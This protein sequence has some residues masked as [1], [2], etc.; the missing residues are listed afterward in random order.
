[1]AGKSAKLGLLGSSDVDS[2]EIDHVEDDH[3]HLKP[4]TDH[5]TNEAH[6]FSMADERYVAK[7]K[8]K[9]HDRHQ[10]NVKQNIAR[11][12]E[13]GRRTA[14]ELDDHMH[15]FQLLRV[16]GCRDWANFGKHLKKF[17]G[18]FLGLPLLCFCVLLL[19][20]M[21]QGT[22]VL[23]N[24]YFGGEH[25]RVALYEGNPFAFGVG[26]A[27]DAAY[28]KYP[29]NET[30]FHGALP[31]PLQ[32]LSK[33]FYYVRGNLTAGFT[34]VGRCPE[35]CFYS[36]AVNGAID[37]TYNDDSP[38]GQMFKQFYDMPQSPLPMLRPDI[39][40]NCGYC[41]VVQRANMF[42]LVLLPCCVMYQWRMWRIFMV[43]FSNLISPQRMML[44]IAGNTL[45]VVIF[46]VVSLATDTD[47]HITNQYTSPFRAMFFWNICFCFALCG[48][49]FAVW[50]FIMASKKEERLKVRYTTHCTYTTHSLHTD[51]SLYT[52]ST[53]FPQAASPQATEE[54]ARALK[55][56]E[57][58]LAA[59]AMFVGSSSHTSTWGG[60]KDFSPSPN[61][62]VQI[63]H[64][65]DGAEAK[66]E[67]GQEEEEIQLNK[68]TSA[69]HPKLNR[70]ESMNRSIK[71][72]KLKFEGSLEQRL[73]KIRRREGSKLHTW[74]WISA[75][76]ALDAFAFLAA[77]IFIF[78][79][80]CKMRDNSDEANMEMLLFLY[81]FCPGVQFLAY[82]CCGKADAKLFIL[83]TVLI[84]Y[85]L[86]SYT[87][88]C[89]RTLCR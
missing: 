35:A 36:K 10:Q 14:D 33:W 5:D 60:A 56:K 42:W 30:Q 87:M 40:L 27:V 89:T 48:T 24:D 79:A 81:C 18:R 4:A 37:D 78:S 57:E 59:A 44:A 68:P 28:E 20:P 66:E 69:S 74:A 88:H 45:I 61:S 64:G 38:Q 76:F 63:P 86:H 2:S 8:A 11:L 3:L 73:F 65:A 43:P 67:E 47:V 23:K 19:M 34:S 41:R 22:E 1:M 31:K 6:S 9:A 21:G 17:Y 52:H 84:H 46:G 77:Q 51:Y 58:M 25:L 55:Q 72:L 32:P 71:G 83:C 26:M 70:A 16:G 53:R 75:T 13:M 54:N 39:A 7:F 49:V 82:F 15:L 85:A 29:L 12:K 50:G 62:K 80:S